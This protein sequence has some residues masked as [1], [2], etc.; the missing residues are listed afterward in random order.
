M[1]AKWIDTFL[2]MKRDQLLNISG[3]VVELANVSGYGIV[4][5]DVEVLD[6]TEY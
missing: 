2:E 4:I 1:K 3:Y 6:P 5:K